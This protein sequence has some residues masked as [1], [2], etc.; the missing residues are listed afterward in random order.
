MSTHIH[1]LTDIDFL[2]V[3][4]ER[5]IQ[6]NAQGLRSKSIGLYD[7]LFH[8]I[9][10]QSEVRGKALILY[11]GSGNAAIAAS[12]LGYDVDICEAD[13]QR[14]AI[15]QDNYNQRILHHVIDLPMFSS[16]AD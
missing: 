11:G 4:V 12:R 7:R 5:A 15:I 13:E 10:S 9:A 16:V 2:T 3:P 6:L 8:P 14:C 1:G